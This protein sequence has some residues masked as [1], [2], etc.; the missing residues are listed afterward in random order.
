MRLKSP[1]APVRILLVKPM[2]TLFV[3]STH[4][5]GGYRSG[6]E[7]FCIASALRALCIPY[8]IDNISAKEYKT[9]GEWCN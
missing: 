1:D 7:V 3:L 4:K 2:P 6:N 8:H 9:S 5:T